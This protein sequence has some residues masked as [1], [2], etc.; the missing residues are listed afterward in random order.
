MMGEQRE[1][2]AMSLIAPL[3]AQSVSGEF[4]MLKKT[5]SHVSGFNDNELMDFVAKV[6][7]KFAYQEAIR[8][9]S[10]QDSF[11]RV[12]FR[13]LKHVLGKHSDWNKL[14][15]HGEKV[16]SNVGDLVGVHVVNIYSFPIEND[17]GD[18]KPISQVVEKLLE[19]IFESEKA[20]VAVNDLLT[21]FR[22]LYRP[23][24]GSKVDFIDDSLASSVQKRIQDSVNYVSHKVLNRYVS[25][26]KYTPE[27]CAMFEKA[28]KRILHDEVYHLDIQPKY[29]YLKSLSIESMGKTLYTEKYQYTFEY[30]VRLTRAHFSKLMKSDLKLA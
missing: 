26:N 11:G 29:E 30:L 10:Q 2:I 23:Q 28:L 15:H 21:R 25:R 17:S 19:K 20:Y 7:R 24:H 4:V 16:I 8:E 22:S 3:F 14:E 18:Q 6:V 9:L 1:A 12:F 13:S 27:E 5:F